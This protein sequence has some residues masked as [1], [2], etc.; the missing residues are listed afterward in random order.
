ML[1][2]KGG[3]S[4]PVDPGHLNVEHRD[5]G[6]AIDGFGKYLITP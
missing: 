4:Q 6:L 1:I 5:I 2:E 3:S